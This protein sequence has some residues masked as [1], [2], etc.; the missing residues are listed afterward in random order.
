MNKTLSQ[1]RKPFKPT[2]LSKASPTRLRNSKRLDKYTSHAAECTQSYPYV[3][4]TPAH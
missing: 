4:P 1:L 2:A 3:L